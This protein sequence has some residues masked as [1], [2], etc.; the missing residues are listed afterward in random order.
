MI[1]QG[2]KA[3]AAG[4]IL[5]GSAASALL[6][7]AA[8]L[9]LAAERPPPVLFLDLGA[10]P[11]AAPAVLA[12]AESAPQVVDQAPQPPEDPPPQ[13]APAALPDLSEPPG[14][15]A[16][17][18]PVTLPAADVPIT[19]DLSLPPPTKRPKRRPEDPLEQKTARAKPKEERPDTRE[20]PSAEPRSDEKPPAADR[21]DNAAPAAAATAPQ[22]GT[23]TRGSG[24]VSPAAYAKA[25]MK[26]VRATRKAA[27]AGKGK[28]VVGFAIAAD[29][30]LSGVQLLRGSGN[31]ALD[32]IA[33]D[34]IRRSAPFPAPPA[35]ADRTYAFEF[36]G[37]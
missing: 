9:A 20:S 35:D 10:L 32:Q 3:R 19:A 30:S 25:V 14:R 6:F 1:A 23:K 24:G 34:H 31:A 37:R 4:W 11:P 18:A 28:V 26:K 7:G 13:E 12:V 2:S 15:R 17:L 22:A 5:A 8:A 27:G 36:V 16:S 29:G 21:G 33:L